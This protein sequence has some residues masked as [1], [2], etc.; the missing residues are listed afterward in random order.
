MVGAHQIQRL[1]V[2]LLRIRSLFNQLPVLLQN[3]ANLGQGLQQI[4]LAD[5]YNGIFGN[6]GCFHGQ[7]DIAVCRQAASATDG[8]G[9]CDP[10]SAIRNAT[11][12][13]NADLGQVVAK[14]ISPP[15][16][17]GG[18]APHG[19]LVEFRAQLASP[20]AVVTCENGLSGLLLG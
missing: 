13:F 18:D 8:R 16:A 12:S 7:P 6:R 14:F 19:N 9:I 2:P 20:E 1:L 11:W 17:S 4:R 10:I 5:D 15:G 3:C